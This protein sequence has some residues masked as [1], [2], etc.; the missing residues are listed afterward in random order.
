MKMC[1]KFRWTLLLFAA[2]GGVCALEIQ[3]GNPPNATQKDNIENVAVALDPASK[4]E[5]MSM[6]VEDHPQSTA[7]TKSG[8]SL[9]LNGLKPSKD[10]SDVSMDDDDDDDDFIPKILAPKMI[11]STKGVCEKGGLT[12]EEGEKLEVGCD[13]VC[14][15]VKGKMDCVDRCQ[16]P[17]IRR[18]KKIDDPLC[19]EKLVE[20]D[21]CCSVMQCTS[22]THE[23]GCNH[24]NKS[25]QFGDIVKDDCEEICTCQNDGHMDCKERCPPLTTLNDKCLKIKD[26][27]DACCMKVIC[28]VT[29]ND[30]KLIGAKYINQSAIKLEFEGNQ[31]LP[32][33]EVSEDKNSWKTYTPLS[34]GFLTN[35]DNN[36][37]YARIE[38]SDDFV[39]IQEYNNEGCEFKG[40]M[41]KFGAEF[42]DGCESFC[43]CKE[44]GVK[45][46]KMD[47]PTYFGTDVLD[48]NC[49]EWETVPTNFTPI[50]PKCCPEKLRCKNNGSCIYQG[51]TY[52]NW[53]QIPENVTGCQ[54]RCYCE[55]NN[56]E[57]QNICPPVT[58]HPPSNLDCLPQHATLGHM[59]GEDCCVYW[60]CKE[61][62]KINSTQ[63]EKPPSKTVGPLVVLTNGINE[64]QNVTKKVLSGQENNYFD[65]KPTA[66]GEYLGPFNP[67]YKPTPKPQ[68]DIKSKPNKVYVTPPTTNAIVP[69][70]NPPSVLGGDLSHLLNQQPQFG[71]NYPIFGIQHIPINPNPNNNLEIPFNKNHATIEQLLQEVHKNRP[72]LPPQIPPFPPHYPIN[73]NGHIF[74]PPNH[75]FTNGQPSHQNATDFGVY[76]HNFASSDVNV[77][78]LEALDAHTV[79][80]VFT[81]PTVFV[82]L[83][84]GVEV[85]YT[86]S[87]NPDVDTWQLQNYTSPDDVIRTPQLEFELLNL[88]AETEYKI[89]VTLQLDGLHNKP[90]SQIY[91]IKTLQENKV[92]T[93]QM[94]PIDPELA[95]TAVNATWVNLSWRKFTD[96]ELQLIDGLQIRFK[97]I[98]GKIYNATALI[99]RAITGFTIDNL[100]PDTKYEVGLFF[101]P[102]AGQPN[103]LYAEHMVNF[104]TTTEY[105]TY[106]FNVTL[107][108]SLIK[109][110][111]IEITWSGVPYPE[112]KYVNIYRAI[113]QSDSGKGDSSTFKMAK[114]DST[115]KV[116]I[117]DLKPGTRYRLWLEVYLTNG[118]IKTSNVQDFI[119]KPRSPPSLGASSKQDKLSGELPD[120]KSDYYG[121]LVVV[122]ILASVAI[123]STLVLLLILFKRH[124]QNKACITPP[125]RVSQSAYDNPT[126]KV[127]IQQE[128]MDL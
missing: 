87:N 42:N 7:A 97:E 45:C 16:R 63:E 98:D 62:S 128:T 46:L 127:E 101:I 91:S 60:T 35:I 41:Y 92:S 47:C 104:A 117:T 2:I 119:T 106:G 10:L 66:N 3:A 120:E 30:N 118:K 121:S 39:E 73:N 44:E 23:T 26:E 6:I 112:D 80:L 25:Y 89:K 96:Y 50:A 19:K 15:C 88:R 90:S 58:A 114:R 105:D 31:T 24:K 14:T 103:E 81:V 54:K 78:I 5:I 29:L 125:P 75:P 94:I 71:G 51:V 69:Q 49:I 11:N 18:G 70:S 4:P 12:Y 17:F 65:K 33:I 113:Y 95:V 40:E 21:S 37:K 102:F 77:D 20:E 76:Q 64:K 107:E 83:R 85:R 72:A 56:V 32:L 122:A 111:N 55:M 52:P 1:V 93:P 100:K 115:P 82:G 38:E 27:N 61:E 68:K 28:D 99:H 86:D 48:P 123:L 84:G 22:D 8:K 53:Q 43:V 67:A 13:S 116:L 79:R 124:S 109:P 110:T 74:I 36:F 34:G 59:P 108:I 126:Y 57:C 9:D